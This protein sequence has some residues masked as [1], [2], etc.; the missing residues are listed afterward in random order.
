M[1]RCSACCLRNC[2][3]ATA[4]RWNSAKAQCGSRAATSP[5]SSAA[6]P[7]RV[8][9]ARQAITEAQFDRICDLLADPR[10][11]IFS[12][13]GRNSDIIAQH[14]TFH[15]RQARG[16][17]FHLPRDAEAWPEYLLRMDAGDVFFLVDFRRYEH[18]LGDLAEMAAARKVKVVLMTDKWM[19]HNKRH[20]AEL[21]VVPIETGTIWD[22]YAAAIAITEALVTRVAE[23]TWDKTRKR[24]ETWDALRSSP[25]ETKE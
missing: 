21:L 6:R 18:R 12:L 19:T 7:E 17:V 4:R 24:I 13:G 10:R 1:P 14:L 2:A 16:N 25:L 3:K 8:Q 11:K 15:M 22:S 20:A 23:T 9:A 5:G